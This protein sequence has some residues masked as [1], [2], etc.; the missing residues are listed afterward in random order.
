MKQA[1]FICLFTLFLA[2][3]LSA[4]TVSVDF[5]D[6]MDLNTYFNLPIEGDV[7]NPA[8]GGMGD[9]GAVLF[10]GVL[11]EPLLWMGVTRVITYK[12][13]INFTEIDEPVTVEAHINSYQN[14]G[15]AA[16]G[17]S[18]SPTNIA[19]NKCNIINVPAMGMQFYSSGYSFFNNGTE[20]TETYLPD[21]PLS[22]YKLIYTIVPRGGDLYDVGY[23][24]WRTNQN[25]TFSILQKS[26]TNSFTNATIND[27]LIYPYFGIDGHRVS[28]VDNFS[29]SYPEE[30]ALPVTMSSFTAAVSSQNLINLQWVTESE[31]NILGFNVYRSDDADLANAIKLNAS[32][33]DGTNTSNQQTYYYSDSEFAPN[34][35]YYYWVES[36]ELDYNSNFF[37]PVSV[38]TGGEED[39][40]PYSV[41]GATGIEKVFPNPFINNTEIAY[42]LRES[43]SVTISIYN[44][45]GQLIRSLVNDTKD[46]GAYHIAWDGK[47]NNGKHCSSGLYFAKMQAGSVNSFY[48]MM[49][50]K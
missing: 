50:V 30:S 29:F 35:T 34:S 8:S 3:S 38:S 1:S 33:I 44:Q 36:A 15:W 2:I 13:G 24:L 48:K 23:E 19:S 6:T 37:G 20:V 31:T 4:V 45:K 43:A 42:K 49:L 47:D 12:N 28:Y 7:T 40:P 22:W 17:F 39:T 11:D 21:I 5:N 27:G 16:L 46:S 14:G 18:S 32:Y 41:E 9:T 25:E 10:P 26:A